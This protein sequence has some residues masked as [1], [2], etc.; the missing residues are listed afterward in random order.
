MSSRRERL[1]NQSQTLFVRHL[2]LELSMD[3]V[4]SAL[5]AYPIEKALDGLLGVAEN[6]TSSKS[7]G[8]ELKKKLSP[9]K[10]VIKEIYEDISKKSSDLDSLPD[11]VKQ[12]QDF[13]ADLNEGLHI[14]DELEKTDWFNLTSKHQYGTQVL[15]FHQK[16]KDFIDIQG[17][18]YVVHDLQ[19]MTAAVEKLGAA[20]RDLERQI[21]E[22]F[23]PRLNSNPISNTLFLQQ[24]NTIQQSQPSQTTVD[25][26]DEPVNAQQSTSCT[27]Q[28]PAIRNSVVGLDNPIDV[29]RQNLLREDVNI[30]EV[31]GMGGSG[32]TTL[33]VEL[34]NDLK[35]KAS[36]NKRIIIPVSQLDGNPNG[37]LDILNTMWVKIVGGP[38]P[39][40]TGI[41]DARAQLQENLMQKN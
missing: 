6:I 32:K 10:A 5:I 13:Q 41:D 29:V 28:D 30:V 9:L 23:I 4:T 36:F 7:E 24:I 19:K 1:E 17:S 25:M 8:K 18:P 20:I 11:R 21:V 14:V 37:I 12:Y 35:I 26:M 2:F 3:G 39:R 38:T 15:D 33:A 34:Y 31:T 40:F 27:L 16:I 22:D